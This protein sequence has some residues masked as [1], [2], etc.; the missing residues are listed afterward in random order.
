MRHCGQSASSAAGASRVPHRVQCFS[1]TSFVSQKNGFGGELL[2]TFCCAMRKELRTAM[3]AARGRAFALRGECFRPG[4]SAGLQPGSSQAK[5]HAGSETGAP[6]LR[7]QQRTRLSAAPTIWVV[8]PHDAPP[9][10]STEARCRSSP[11]ISSGDV[12]VSAIS[13]RMSSPKRWRRRWTA[14]PTAEGDIFKSRAATV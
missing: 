13:R 3:S 11:S 9:R 6:I 4:W 7:R 2:Q 1:F 14:T 8:C 10:P 5:Q 12:T